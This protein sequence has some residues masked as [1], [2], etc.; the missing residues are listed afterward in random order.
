MLIHGLRSVVSVPLVVPVKSIMS[1]IPSRPEALPR[2]N[3]L[4]AP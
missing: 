4:A 3:K 2:E 1:F